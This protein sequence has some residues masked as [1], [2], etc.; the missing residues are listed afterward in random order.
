MN[1][2]VTKSADA[3]RPHATVEEAAARSGTKL[4][5]AAII[6]VMVVVVAAIAGLVPRW[7][8]RTALR[9]ETHD[10]ALQTVAVVSAERGKAA[11]GLTLPA[12]VKPFLDAPI[13]ARSSGYL[14]NW[15]VDIGG[16]VKEGEIL[17]E[18]DAP[19]LRQELVRAKA[20]LAQTEAALAL[21]KITA[22]R[23]SE[24]LKTASVSDQEA[25]EKKA[26][27]ELKSANVAAAHAAVRRLEELQSF[28]HV[29]APFAGTI[30]ARGTDV[31]QLIVGGSG[32]EL[33]HLTQTSSLRVYVR[34]PQ[35]AARAIAVGQIAELTIPELPGRVFPAKVVRTSGAMSTDSRTLLAELQ[36]D[37]SKNEILAGT[38]AQV[39]F[40]EADMNPPLT[41]PSNTLL[42]R[43]EGLQVGVVAADG[44]VSLHRV[45]VGRDF[46]STIEILEGVSPTDKVIL[47]P[48]DSLVSGI[49]VRIA[50]APN[51]SG[52]K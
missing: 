51:S 38:Y 35:M 33:F 1:G 9:A 27:F 18:I 10:L 15:F 44:K 48:P 24:L 12:E 47:N 6:A 42:F 43:A 26:D 46:G 25:A 30:T 21:A 20:E 16:H 11:A 52:G 29:R 2:T 31:G 37:N 36:V 17:A 22:E 8:Q 41:L 23:W 45:S 39:R 19:E 7:R 3:Q 50:A 34:V 5:H 28:S 13:Y 40:P 4:R 32:K 14:T 49:L